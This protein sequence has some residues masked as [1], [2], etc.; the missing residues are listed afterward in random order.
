MMHSYLRLTVALSAAMTCATF[1]TLGAQQSP[2]GPQALP[3]SPSRPLLVCGTDDV[4]ATTRGVRP[5]VAPSAGQAMCFTQEPSILTPDYAGAVMLSNFVVAGDVE[6]IRFQSVAPLNPDDIETW[7]RTDTQTINGQLVSVFN[8]VWGGDALGRVLR[9]FTFGW[10]KPRIEWGEVLPGET[11]PGGGSLIFLRISPRNLQTSAVVQLSGDVQYSSNIVNLRIP[12]HG[13]TRFGENQDDYDLGTVS[14]M[15]YEHFEDSYD[16]L[17]IVPHDDHLAAYTAFHTVLK[18]EVTGIGQPLIDDSA[19]FG[20]TGRLKAYEVYLDGSV[21]DNLTTSHETAHQWGHYFDWAAL[22][23]LVRAGS[24]A[25]AHS[26]LW[27]T[28][29]TFMAGLLEPTRRLAVV[30]GAW[31]VVRTP[32]LARFHPFMR[33]AMGI[34][35]AA[36]V[37]EITLFDEQGQFAGIVEPTAGTPV[38]GATRTA[39][40]FNAIGMLGERQ[41]PVPTD[42]QRATIVVT[43]DRL[44][45]QAEMDYWT[46][47]ARRIEDPFQSGVATRQGIPSFDLSTD[48]AIDLV[49]TIRPKVAAPLVS[50]LDVNSPAL[51]PTSWRGITFDAP[52]KTSYA[53]GERVTISGRVTASDRTDF[54]QIVLIFSPD[55]GLPGETLQTAATVSAAGTFV[56]S[57]QLEAQHVGT[58]ALSAYL[59]WPGAPNQIPR[60]TL[61]PITVAHAAATP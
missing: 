20:S 54:S 40:V 21:N 28:D 60:S 31:Q 10:D 48:R 51:D 41:G 38:A 50:V 57:F 61:T 59:F 36:S 14:T 11:Q 13:A 47:F 34:L 25:E 9:S 37:P 22:T 26:P 27:A 2:Q 5:L 23:G 1:V 8:P 29:E 30:D 4:L 33:Y 32:T 49:T 39:T 42:W 52:I 55:T 24:Q 35:P 12:G 53:V 3:P 56:L 7:T 46:F 6:T 18:N 15:F 19:T 44:L 45:T 58:H 16:V 43:R 17:A